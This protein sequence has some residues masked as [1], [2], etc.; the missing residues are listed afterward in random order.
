LAV[1]LL[2]ACLDCGLELTGGFEGGSS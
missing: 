1:V 2:F